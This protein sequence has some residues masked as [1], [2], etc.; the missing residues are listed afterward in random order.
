MT[1]LRQP[2]IGYIPTPH[3]VTRSLLDF[4]KVTSS[5]IL[6]DLG[7]GDG[8]ILIEAAQRW[9]TRGVG[10]DIDPKRIQQAQENTQTAR[11]SD[12]IEFR[13]EDLFKSDFHQATVVFIYLLP[14]L[15]LRLRSRL[16]RQLQPGSRIISK[17]FDLGDWPPL[18]TLFLPAKTE[19]DEEVTLYYWRV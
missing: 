18:H 8:R 19:D 1:L 14:H 11:V 16:K 9:G 2:D 17:D 7:S 13:Q 10:I 3:N 4:A 5:D 6:Y 12:L 15:N